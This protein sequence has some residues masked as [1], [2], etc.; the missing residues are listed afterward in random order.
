MN[1]IHSICGNHSSVLKWLR[2]SDCIVTVLSGDL[3]NT[4]LI[5]KTVLKPHLSSLYRFPRRCSMII[6]LEALRPQSVLGFPHVMVMAAKWWRLLTVCLGW[7]SSC[8]E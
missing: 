7:P 1:L 2:L 3:E 6:L 8:D 5:L 4:L